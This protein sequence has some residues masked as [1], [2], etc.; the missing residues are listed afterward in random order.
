MVVV[1]AVFRQYWWILSSN[2]YYPVVGTFTY[3]AFVYGRQMSC[4]VRKFFV[5]LPCIERTGINCL[6][7]RSH[8]PDKRKPQL[9][10]SLGAALC[11]L[12]PHILVNI[13]DIILVLP[14]FYIVHKYSWLIITN[15]EPRHHFIVIRRKHSKHKNFFMWQ[16]N[17]TTDMQTRLV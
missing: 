1:S 4:T 17:N 2:K 11:M 13:E 16:E 15:F 14:F 6:L 8:I 7:T 3:V 9:P 10:F 12:N 5:Q